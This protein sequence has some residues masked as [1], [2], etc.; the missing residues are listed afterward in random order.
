MNP[1]LQ[2]PDLDG[3][4]FYWPAGKVGVLLLHGLTATTVEVRT[5]GAMLHEQGYTVAGPLLPGHGTT[6]DELSRTTWEQWLAVADDAYQGLCLRCDTIFVGG[7][8]MGGL[9]TLYLASMHADIAGIML[10]A[11]ALIVDGARWARYLAP[12]WRFQRKKRVDESMPWQGYYVNPIHAA[13][14][15]YK[16]QRQVLVRLPGIQTPTL[17]MQG[18]LDMT[19]NTQS[20]QVVYDRIGSS[21]KELHWLERSGHVLILAQELDVVAQRT[22]DFLKKTLTE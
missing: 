1:I 16:L 7:E 9:L 11:P 18:R 5:L 10:Y 19:I 15:L 21:R 8:S 20:A 4:S 12:F 3:T 14:E 13:A 6:P 22:F 2:H 17:I